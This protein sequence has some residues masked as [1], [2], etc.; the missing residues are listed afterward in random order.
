MHQVEILDPADNDRPWRWQAHT[1]PGSWSE[2][3][4]AQLERVAVLDLALGDPMARRVEAF[5]LL[6]GIDERTW[7]RLIDS[8]A[9]ADMIAPSV[10]VNDSGA[11]EE[12]MEL[13]PQLRWMDQPPNYT[14]SLIP[15]FRFH[16]LPWDGPH[17]MLIN[18]TVQ[19]WGVV[20]EHVAAFTA[21]PSNANL[22]A[23][24]GSMYHVRWGRWTMAG[25][26]RRGAMLSRLRVRFKLATVLNYQALR[27][28]VVA[29]YPLSFAGGASDPHGVHGLIVDL[30]GTTAFAGVDRAEKSLLHDVLVHTERVLQRERDRERKH[31]TAT[32]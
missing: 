24:I 31:N 1:L 6:T 2:L 7:T 10:R 13:L 19:R 29:K 16:A 11:E 12:V 5:R 30:A 3:T 14:K 8:D 26:D 27:A 18:F 25:T 22:N 23:L 9:G 17:D 32:S 20:D 4:R 15:R 21:Q 28:A